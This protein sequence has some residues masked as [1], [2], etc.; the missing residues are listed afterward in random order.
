MLKKWASSRREDP[1]RC[2]L[3]RLGNLLLFKAWLAGKN[4]VPRNNIV[5][6]MLCRIR[7]ISRI[8]PPVI[9]VAKR[10]ATAC[11]SFTLLKKGGQKWTA[12]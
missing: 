8:S 2:S 12:W 9:P 7:K 5:V 3:I 11:S 10:M 1:S 6:A 4:A